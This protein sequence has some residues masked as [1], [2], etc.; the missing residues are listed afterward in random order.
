MIN[1]DIS[2]VWTCVTL[3][4]LLGSEKEIFDAHNLLRNNQS[5]GPDLLGWLGLPDSIQA[6]L[7]HSI[8]RRA[9]QI[10]AYSDVLVVCGSGHAYDGA[11][12]AVELYCGA[13]R[14]LISR[15]QIFF[16]GES[17][18]GRQ[19]VELSRMLEDQDYSLHII[20]PTG[21]ELGA[22]VTARGL[23][24]MME[25]KY[26]G[27]AKER[28]SVATVVGTALHKMGQ[29]EGY[30]I[31]PMP[32]QLGGVDSSLTAAAL[33][34]MAV[35]GIDPL[36]VLEGAADS[37]RELDMRSFENPAWLYAAARSVL[38]GK[39]RRRELL[40]VFDHSLAAFGR[41]WQRYAWRHEP[42]G[43][44]P[45]TVFLPGDL[46]AME[47]MACDAG[48][49]FETVLHFDPIAKKLPVEMDWKDY[50]GL[51]FLSGRHLDYVEQQTMAAMVECH[52]YAGVPVLDLYAGELTAQTLGELFCFFELSSALAGRVAGAD[53]FESPSMR[54]LD[55][56]MA[57]MSAL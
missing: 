46:Q 52:N 4:E 48:R 51:G 56:A 13:G 57:A 39:G 11:R 20:S 9:E 3:P 32:R 29:E 10:C 45:E 7:I 43:V 22:N 23:R 42:G 35:A 25:R 33:I 2:N 24:W 49:V 53:P 16:A 38:P 1:V 55:G 41:W 19:W 6:R 34:P 8:R 5:D 47:D 15:P 21:R 14:N 31:F 28:I 27:K 50:D 54:T 17:L 18:S 12:A 26:G 40:C 36:S 37:Y 30:E 44:E